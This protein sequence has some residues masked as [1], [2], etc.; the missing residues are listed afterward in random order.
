MAEKMFALVNGANK[1]IGRKIARQLAARG[2]VV[3]IGARDVERGKEAAE[4][5][6]ADGDVRFVQLAGT[7]FDNVR[8]SVEQGAAIAVKLATLPP[9]G[10]TG[11]FF[12]D[13]G[14][15]PW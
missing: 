8:G 13:D 12:N 6:R 3:W 10:P 11:G 5:L 14:V 1:G 9:D 4:A 2:I 15:V 7:D